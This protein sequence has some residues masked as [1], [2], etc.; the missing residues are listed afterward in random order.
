MNRTKN[1]KQCR[2][3]QTQKLKRPNIID[4]KEFHSWQQFKQA[5]FTVKMKNKLSI[6]LV[7]TALLVESEIREML[8]WGH[9]SV[10]ITNL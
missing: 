5:L 3:T 10:S 8:E 4:Y 2:R 7:V 9:S 6:K 1:Y